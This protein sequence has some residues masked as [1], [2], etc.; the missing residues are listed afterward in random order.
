MAKIGGCP[1]EK[2]PSRP[3][4]S[5]MELAKMALPVREILIIAMCSREVFV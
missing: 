2:I 5:N 3:S 4:F 1:R